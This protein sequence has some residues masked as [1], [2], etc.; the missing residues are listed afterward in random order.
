MTTKG[1]QKARAGVGAAKL[2]GA[3][4]AS[5]PSIVFTNPARDERH[6]SAWTFALL[7][8]LMAR[9]GV[10]R[11]YIT[12]TYRSPL[13][14]ARVM[15]GNLTPGKSMYAGYGRR[16]EQVARNIA[17]MDQAVAAVAE[18]IGSMPGVKPVGYTPHSQSQVIAEMAAEIERLEAQHGQGCVSKHQMDPARMNVVDIGSRTVTPQSALGAF[19]AA[20]TASSRIER[21]GLPKG[22]KPTHR[23]HFVETQA[24]IHLEIPQPNDAPVSS[25]ATSIA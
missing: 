22:S 5:Q 9:A 25:W 6:V 15:H 7:E 12:S 20:L 11:I 13:D 4:S 10:K 23:K 8:S 19:I 17:L 21:I 18:A 1:I 16:V 24:C 3:A 2:G 14:Q